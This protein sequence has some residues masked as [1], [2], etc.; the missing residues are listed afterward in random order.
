MINSVHVKSCPPYDDSGAKIKN[1]KKVNFI[2][3]ANGSGKTTISEYLRTYS[4]NPDRFRF[5]EID[6]KSNGP[7]PI[8]V[9]NRQFR[10]LNFIREEGIP[11]VF[12][13]GE[14]AIED[15]LEIEQ[16][17]EELARKEEK[18]NKTKESIQNKRAEKEA[19]EKEFKEHAWQQIL[20]RHESDFSNAF[21]GFRSNKN[22]FIDEL[23]RRTKNPKGELVGRTKLLERSSALFKRKPI[24]VD[25][26][27]EISEKSLE[28]VERIIGDSIWRQVIVG[29]DDVDIA[30]L[31]KKLDN[32]SWVHKGM[33]YLEEDSSVC[34][35]CQK[36]T[37]D[38]LFRDELNKFFNQEYVE[39]LDYMKS[40]K[41]ELVNLVDI[42]IN[43]L[44]TNLEK[45]DACDIAELNKETY[46]ALIGKIE[47][48][49]ESINNKIK[50]KI[51]VPEN[52]ISFPELLE[53]L[54]EINELTST[55]NVRIEQNN[56][57]VKEFNKEYTKLVDDVWCY[58]IKE[59]ESLIKEY[60]KAIDSTNKALDGM[61]KS[62]K[63][64][65]DEIEK[66]K[67]DIV[68]KSNNLT[69]VQPA[70]NQINN[71]LV[72]Y[73]FT[74]FRIEPYSEVPGEQQNK[75]RIVRED[76][77]E[78]THT[79]SEGEATFITFLYF[80]QL[81]KGAT[82]KESVNE[83]KII[84]LD[85]PISS[86]DSNVLYLVS[87][88]VKKLAKE[89]KSGD[90]DVEQLFIFTH[91]VYFHK[92]AS[93]INVRTTEDKDVNF[94]I[95]RKNNGVS[96]IQ[97]YDKVNPISSTYELL[98]KEL[99]EDKDISVVSMQ[100]IMR[101]IIENYF[102]IMGQKPDDYILSKFET[103][104]EKI[105]C[106]SLLYWINDG[107]HT[108]YDDLHIDQYTDISDIFK[109]VFKQI[110]EKT[111]HL[112]HYKMMMGYQE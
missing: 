91:N 61:E 110:F 42:I 6:W 71:T 66:L 85:D 41:A 9:Y 12:T 10:K 50:D 94:W 17:K 30:K 15:K 72:A 11:G 40:K 69:S 81:T 70:V 58:C 88:M 82:D 57:L 97:S 76:G 109:N 35:F 4:T 20:K 67:R 56:N 1:C 5:C 106:E 46:N 107:S 32:S 90:S 92:E 55:F 47:A 18:H 13:L 3:G 59:T 21:E 93:F 23:E 83:K 64:A 79:L 28:N 29:S 101:R 31:I 33:E 74:N 100:N 60:E 14:D 103:Q 38:Q 112:E 102:K 52:K 108:I 54:N 95:V 45:T 51:M 25:K 111:N 105:V 68:Q 99:R 49:F 37:I 98:W 8:Y 78:A 48:Q 34:P 87:A 62:K 27:Y 43:K 89:I 104:E 16:L 84:V 26:L 86:L 65:S 44:R 75:Y 24:K 22:R 7:L 53:T 77:T 2:Y 63:K 36:K 96:K 73:G 39:K 80:M 19:I